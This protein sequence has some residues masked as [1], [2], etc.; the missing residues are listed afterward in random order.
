ME[1]SLL[2]RGE[3]WQRRRNNDYF[4]VARH[5]NCFLIV[6]W[7]KIQIM[8]HGGMGLETERGSRLWSVLLSQEM[9]QLVEC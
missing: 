1:R 4:H 8:D 2:E 7:R 5:R 6:R 9:V 3:R